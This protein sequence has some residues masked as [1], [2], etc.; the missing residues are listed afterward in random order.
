MIALNRK[1]RIVIFAGFIILSLMML[2][3]AWRYY[4]TEEERGGFAGY[5]L[6]FAPQIRL[7]VSSDFRGL[8]VYFV[9]SSDVYLD[10]SM[11]A[12]QCAFVIT[13]IGGLCFALHKPK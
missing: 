8:N 6:L 10:T 3:P 13:I 7:T 9:N 12:V 5:G 11:L 4:R 1:Q 2:F